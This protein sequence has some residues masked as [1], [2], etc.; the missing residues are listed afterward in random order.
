MKLD[1]VH[2][3]QK[4]YRKLL[5]CMSRPGVI[6]SIKEQSEKIDFDI[7]FYKGTL[8][9][10]YMLL[11]GEV[12]FNIVSNNTE[13]ITKFVNQLTYAKATTL[14]EADF[15]FILRD[16]R[17]NSLGDAFK[18][19]KIGTLIDP[20]K[21]AT[22][23]VEVEKLTTDRK[24]LLKGP[25]IEDLCQVNIIT[26]C[27]FVEERKSKNIEY[28]LGVDTVFIDKEDQIMCLPRTTSI[29]E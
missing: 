22:I 15:I 12:T 11:D 6:E 2:D 25:G 5:N 9:N 1:L 20:H 17:E 18:N 8:I 29:F 19:A 21:A 23:I 13:E 16:A 28:P 24:Y 27:L 10:M 7:S 3:T 4:A 26:Q 14:E